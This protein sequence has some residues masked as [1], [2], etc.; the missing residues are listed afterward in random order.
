LKTKG[1]AYVVLVNTVSGF[2]IDRIFTDLQTRYDDRVQSENAKGIY[3]YGRWVQHRH[4][5]LLLWPYSLGIDKFNFFQNCQSV[6]PKE[7][8]RQTS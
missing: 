7:E 3:G 8:V 1:G 2:R 4:D 6:S 5:G